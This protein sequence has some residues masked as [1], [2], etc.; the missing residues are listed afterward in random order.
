MTSWEFYALPDDERRQYGIPPI[1]HAVYTDQVARVATAYA[2]LHRA[3][4][5]T[6]ALDAARQAVETLLRERRRPEG[7]MLQTTPEGAE[8]L[9][10]DR[11][12]RA[13]R[14][15]ERFYLRPQ[16]AFGSA[17]IAL[18]DETHER[19]YLEHAVA[20]AEVVRE[21]LEDRTDGGFTAVADPRSSFEAYIPRRE[22]L[23]VARFL[24]DLAARRRHH[25]SEARA[26]RDSALRAVRRLVRHFG[27]LDTWGALVGAAA[28]VL[29]SLA[30]GPI[31][32]SITGPTD[33][34][35][36]QELLQAARRVRGPRLFAGYDVDGAYP[37]DVGTA[38]FVCTDIA[39]SNPIEDTDGLRAAIAE[40]AE[41]EEDPCPM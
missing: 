13:F 41:I 22:N 5:E 15:D 9:Q 32:V 29:D 11:R 40:A 19:R 14:P 16:G 31:E 24:A 30:L 28:Y 6:F 1:D 21:R 10:R 7:W 26:Y 2:Q 34:P 39:C 37:H 20:L 33:A 12:M 25:T 17:L 36:A 23:E 27:R 18:F 3:T 35:E 4:G 38:A 8:S